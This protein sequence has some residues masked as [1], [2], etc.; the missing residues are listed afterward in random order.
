MAVLSAH[1]GHFK[2]KIKKRLF[3]FMTVPVPFSLFASRKKQGYE[4][5]R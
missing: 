1:G 2:K 4:T 3:L 5:A